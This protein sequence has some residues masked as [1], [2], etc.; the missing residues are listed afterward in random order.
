MKGD[1]N[2]S[3]DWRPRVYTDSEMITEKN[4]IYITTSTKEK[5]SLKKV[6]SLGNR[7]VGKRSK[8]FY[9]KYRRKSIAEYSLTVGVTED[10]IKKNKSILTTRKKNH[11]KTKLSFAKVL[12]S[13]NRSLCSCGNDLHYLNEN[14][15]VELKKNDGAYRLKGLKSCGN[16]AS[17]PVCA[18]KLS[19][20]RSSQLKELME[21]GK[22]NN[23][24][25]MM[26]VV[27][28]PHK[29]KEPLSTTLNQVI[30]MSR[31]IFNSREWKN[32]K[33]IT[34]CRF[35][36]GG[37]ENMVSFKNGLIDWHPHKNYLLDFDISIKD[38]YKKLNL[39]N[40]HDLRMYVSRMLTKLGQNYLF[41]NSIKKRLLSPYF[42][43]SSSNNNLY[44]K[45]GISASIDFD[46]TY[47]SKWGL[48][49]EMTSGI[50][51]DGRFNGGSFH[52]FGLLDLIDNDNRDVCDKQKYQAV[53]AFQEFVVASKGKWWFYF[54]RGAVSYY[55]NNYGS[56]I[57]VKKDDEEL[58]SFE[59]V[60]DVLDVFTFKDWIYFK[61]TTKKI[62]KAF[63][64]KS[65]ADVVSFFRQE[66]IRNRKLELDI[67]YSNS[68]IKSFLLD[69]EEIEYQEV[70]YQ[71]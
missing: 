58:E 21:I 15:I 11:F 55:N 69:G 23:R 24:G 19:S 22:K 39:D 7:E 17:C 64:L 59:D 42:E 34:K 31:Y 27:T 37:L 20:V 36:H 16:N 61:S 12:K 28:I 53:R 50:Y 47:I 4:K 52:P 18:S 10:F 9:L 54:G 56:K 43:Q 49:A 62:Y 51:K 44:L 5:S 60:G 46:D 35:L 13:V 45:G 30:D 2:S 41:S 38:I 1:I 8:D 70:E 25:Y 3:L 29:P 71:E 65:D 32:F 26:V 14:S 66:I 63:S 67:Y 33:K 68:V 40:E 6:S 48:S 57:K